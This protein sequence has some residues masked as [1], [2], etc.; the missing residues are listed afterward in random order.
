MPTR[1]PPPWSTGFGNF[2]VTS[3]L[4]LVQRF[5]A[6]GIFGF[7]RNIEVALPELPADAVETRVSIGNA[8]SK[9]PR[10]HVVVNGGY[11]D[12]AKGRAAFDEYLRALKAAVS[13]RRIAE[14]EAF[15]AIQRPD[16]DIIIEDRTAASGQRRVMFNYYDNADPGFASCLAAAI[17][18]L[19]ESTG[20]TPRE[21]S[22]RAV[23]H[24]DGFDGPSS[25]QAFF[26]YR[27]ELSA[28]TIKIVY[29]DLDDDIDVDEDVRYTAV[30]PRSWFVDSFTLVARRTLEQL[31]ALN[32]AL[33]AQ[34]R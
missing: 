3:S 28:D 26:G 34:Q 15:Y 17:I 4:R 13:G 8:G 32:R 10:K 14:P 6:R 29:A 11:F 25:V 9:R 16:I 21:L 30:L 2:A 22:L 33:S 24:I 12:D 31:N 1:F 18:G 19:N 7:K 5:E 27:T 20:E 23:D